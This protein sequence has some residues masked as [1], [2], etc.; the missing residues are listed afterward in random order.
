MSIFENIDILC[1]I[2]QFLPPESQLIIHQVSKSFIDLQVKCGK[3]KNKVCL[4]VI[5]NGKL[6]CYYCTTI[7]LSKKELLLWE[8][9]DFLSRDYKNRSYLKC[10][11]CNL[12]CKSSEWFHYHIRFKC[13]KENAY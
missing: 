6:N 9:F 8:K 13:S 2:F 7:L 11:N 4:P 12:R 5:F 10:P 1:V 3:C